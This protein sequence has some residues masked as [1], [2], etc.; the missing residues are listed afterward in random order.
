MPW[1]GQRPTCINLHQSEK[2][3]TKFT[4]HENWENES[5]RPTAKAHQLSLHANGIL[6]LAWVVFVKAS[7]SRSAFAA[8][9]S[10]SIGLR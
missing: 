4:I 10:Q 3:P 5:L 7:Y 9:R 6:Y 8:D 2:T 1:L